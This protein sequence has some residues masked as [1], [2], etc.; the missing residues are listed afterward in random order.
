MTNKYIKVKVEGLAKGEV[1]VLKPQNGEGGLIKD[2]NMA[3]LFTEAE[4][5]EVRKNIISQVNPEV[6]VTFDLEK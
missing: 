4:A 5:F 2:P 3:T 1:W 6:N